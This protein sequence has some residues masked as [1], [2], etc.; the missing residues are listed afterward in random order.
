MLQQAPAVKVLITSR[1]RLNLAAEW[2][3]DLGTER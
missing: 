2:L 3:V 1:E